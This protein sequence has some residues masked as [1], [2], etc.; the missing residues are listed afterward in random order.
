[1]S[2]ASN[3]NGSPN[4]QVRL[5]F[6]DRGEFYT[7]TVSIPADRL[8]AYDRLVDLL[9]EDPSVTQQLYVDFRRLVSAVVAEEGGD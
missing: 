5:L 4:A 2:T 1:M 7:E 8:G 9:R 3:G 6:A